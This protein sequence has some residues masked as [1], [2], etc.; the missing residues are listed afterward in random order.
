[1][2]L[3][4]AELNYPVHE[5]ELLSIVRAMKKWRG[6]LL[7]EYFTVFTDHKPLCHFMQQRDLS[8]R[9]SRWQDYM[10]DFHFEIKYLLGEENGAAD[11]L[12][13]LP[14]QVEL[15]AAIGN[16]LRIDSDPAW[17]NTIRDG[18]RTD[19]WCRKLFDTP[20]IPGVRIENSL[21]YVGDRLVIPRVPLV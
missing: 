11:A 4:G 2:Q 21:L 8:R 14:K 20:S 6:D 10:S 15:V 19:P 16:S 12:S 9:Q 3:K 18:Y 17:Y 1:M 7:G 5:K 13:R